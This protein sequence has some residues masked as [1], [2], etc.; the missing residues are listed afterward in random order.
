MTLGD[1]W[2]KATSL[3][4]CPRLFGA[5]L[6]PPFFW[7]N[8]IPEPPRTLFLTGPGRPSGFVPQAAAGR[9]LWPGVSRLRSL[10]EE[11]PS[12]GAPALP[13]DAS[14]DGPLDPRGCEPP[15]SASA[16]VPLRE[17]SC[18]SDLHRE[19]GPPS[20]CSGLHRA[21]DPGALGFCRGLDL[22]QSDL[23]VACGW[24]K[25]VGSAQG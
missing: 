10:W 2:L 16:T 22:S 13:G 21:G 15:I 8:H 3:G 12:A 18:H 23:K 19:P 4:L 11:Q 9:L 20:S 5:H 14:L 25:W 24:I 7:G 6:P 17:G 1:P